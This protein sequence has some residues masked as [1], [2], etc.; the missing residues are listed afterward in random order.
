[1]IKPRDP[2]MRSPWIQARGGRVSA[3]EGPEAGRRRAAPEQNRNVPLPDSLVASAGGRISLS[4]S[5]LVGEM[6]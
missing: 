1:M 4:G 2:E 3:S 5:Y 6:G